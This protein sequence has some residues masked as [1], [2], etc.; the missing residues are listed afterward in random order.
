MQINRLSRSQGFT[1]VELLVVIAIIAVLATIAATA[2]IR[3]RAAADRSASIGALRQLQIANVSYAT[4]N[5]GSFVPPEAKEVNASGV[6]TGVTYKWFENPDFISQIK[7]ELATFSGSGSTDF[8][9]PLALMDAAVVRKK[10]AENTTL[11]ICF[12]YTTPQNVAVLKQA[13]LSNPSASAAFIT[14]DSPF[15]DHPTKSKIAYRHQNKALVVYYDGRAAVITR[16]EIARIDSKGGATNA[17]WKADSE[18]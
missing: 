18:Q 10:S 14:C 13:R 12:G 3:F 9:V 17:F 7:G 1:L 16:A 15:I 11:D 8:S 4:E 6:E 2:T 5:G